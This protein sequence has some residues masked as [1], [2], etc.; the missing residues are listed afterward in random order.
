MRLDRKEYD[1]LP[2]LLVS[3]AGVSLIEL[4]IAIAILAIGILGLIAGGQYLHRGIQTSKNVGLATNLAQE[5]IEHLKNI[6]Y[7]E[8]IVTTS[9][10]QDSCFPDIYYDTGFFPPEE[11]ESGGVTFR[12]LTRVKKVSESISG[13]LQSLAWNSP[14]AGLRQIEVSVVWL[15]KGE[16]KR[17][18]LRNLANDPNRVKLE[19]SFYGTVSSGTLYGP[20]LQNVLVEVLQNPSWGGLSGSDG[21]YFFSVSPGTYTLRASLRGYFPATVSG[22][23]IADDELL[24]QDFAMRPMSSGTISGVAYVRDHPVISQVMADNTQGSYSAEFVELYNPTTFTWAIA[25]AADVP[26]LKLYYQRSPSYPQVELECDYNVRALESGK[27]FLFANTTTITLGGVSRAADAVFKPTLLGYPNMIYATGDVG[28]TAAGLKLVLASTGEK[29]DAVGWKQSSAMPEVY[30]GLPVGASSGI[31]HGEQ[32]VRKVSSAGYSSG[33][34]RAYDSDN[35]YFDFLIYN[36]ALI[37]PRNSYDSEAPRTGTPASEAVVSADDGLSSPVYSAQNGSFVLPSVATGTWTVDISSGLYTIEVSSV[38]VHTNLDTPIN[39]VGLRSLTE[40]GYISGKVTNEYNAPI[41]NIMISA[42]GALPA[43]TDAAG[44]YV[45]AVATGPISVS[46]NR[47]NDNRKYTSS[48]RE[49]VEICLGVMTSG[50]NFTLS[51]GGTLTGFVSPNGVDPYPG[52]AFEARMY[53]LSYGSVVSDNTGKFTI[54]NLPAGAYDIYAYGPNSE[55]VSPESVSAVVTAG[56]TVFSSSFTVNGGFGTVGGSLTA[57]GKS[58]GT[59]VLLVASTVTISGVAP[60][61]VSAALRAGGV[62]YY[63]KSSAADGTYAIDLPAGSYNIY[64]WYTDLSGSNPVTVKK[65]ATAV[66]TSA[67]RSIVNFVW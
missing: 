4:I 24:K 62:K 8:L 48:L 44:N 65:S 33:Y 21:G 18:V 58:I 14:D 19:S 23:A 9:T 63:Q 60:P 22:L 27:Y 50:I 34:G 52:V 59:G 43:Y 66:V 40:Y 17:L 64:A 10:A 54:S 56:D 7:P 2:G 12:R 57:G 61:D 11:I 49:D 35:N 38:A 37:P 16:C 6:S 30:E 25:S 1:V 32:F 36:P 29:L 39:E 28:S 5:K 55:Q 20:S 67:N 42:P 45:L 26:A 46:A 3:P 53:G 47:G 31:N 41:P 15:E 51:S 13:G